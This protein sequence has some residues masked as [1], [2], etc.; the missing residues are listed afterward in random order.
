MNVTDPH[1]L[2]A[3]AHTRYDQLMSWRIRSIL[4]VC[5]SF[6]AF[7]LE[8]DGQLEAQVYREYIELHVS[9]PP[10][11]T[12]VNTTDQARGL[13]RQ[14]KA[15]D[16]IICM[17]NSAD[18]DIFTFSHEIQTAEVHTP[19]VLLSTYSREFHK[20]LEQEDLSCIDYVFTW[21]GNADL[22]L[23]IIKLIEDQKNAERDILELGVQAIL[24]I[25]DSIRYYSTYLPAIYKLVIQQ[26]REFLNDVV[27]EQQKKLRKRARPKILLANN[28][29]DALALYQKYKRSLLGVISDIGFVVHKNDPLSLEKLDAGIDLCKTIQAD[30]PHMPI[31]LQSSQWS[32][33]AF[34]DEL[35]V[36]FLLKYS[37]TL[38][39]ELAQYISDEFVFGDFVVKDPLSGE[40][41]SR[42][43]NLKEMQA[44][45]QEIPEEHL[46]E[47]TSRNRLSKW[48]VSRGLFTLASKLRSVTASD[49]T[50]TEEIRAYIVQVIKDYRILSGQGVIARFDPE[51][52]SRYIWYARSG[53]GP[54]G[55]KARGLAFLNNLLQRYGLANRYPGV[56]ISIPRT[57]VL[58]TDYF[59]HFIVENGLQYVVNAEN[60]TDEDILSEFISSRLPEDLVQQL[61]VF[62]STVSTPLAVRSSSTLEDSNFQPFAGIYSTYMI[63]LTENK[64]QM[65]RLLS[66]A[67]K[68]VYASVYF[69]AARA[70]IQSSGN[71]LSEEKMGIVLQ[72]VCGS[73][74]QGYY[75]PTFS[76]VAKSI[77]YYPIGHE[78][79]EDG[80]VNLAYGLGKL[81]VE[82]G[83]SLRFSPRYPK[84]ILQLSTVGGALRETQQEMYALNLRPE[85]FKTSID[86]GVNIT[87]FTL[88]EADR[89]RN[90]KH[91]ASTWDMQ[92]MRI[93][94]GCFT[95]GRRI[96]TFAHIL[97]YDT[98]PLP[99]ILCDLLDICEKELRCHVEIEF[100]CNMDVPKGQD[101]IFNVLQVRPV[102]DNTRQD[103]PEL[104]PQDKEQALIYSP[105]ALGRRGVE[106]IRD[107]IYVKQ[108]SFDSSRTH[109]IASELNQLNAQL[110][111]QGRNYIL[112]GPGRW[113]SSDPFLGIPV[114]WNH[115][116]EAR[117]M[118]ECALPH[119]QPEPSQGTHFFQNITSLGVGYLTV[120]PARGL[121]FFKQEVVDAL[122]A[123]YDGPFLRAVTVD[124]PFRVAIN[125]KKGEAAVWRE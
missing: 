56:R 11:I 47:H 108:A 117:M 72:S 38:L 121:G 5:S 106:G 122:P 20:R 43:R 86:D 3:L 87:R 28:Y 91:V 9:N 12:W 75:F 29:D 37:K 19:V 1:R 14:G 94:P 83:Q 125:G 22:I 118:V 111:S 112:V 69:A 51:N 7:I 36:G 71:L 84:S 98:L 89:F 95:Q 24:L 63:P 50:S 92:N 62:L 2:T 16:L 55:G 115:I 88:A 13:L 18:S 35:G 39:I 59:D 70:Y 77:N 109:E 44:L 119:F 42:A 31:L 76:G 52:Y 80:V 101:A 41:L 32:R 116:S 105:S 104:T 81:V 103:A 34:A 25:E 124:E 64:D 10:A 33:K 30:D 27:S 110:R 4:M 54:L 26:S 107:L 21:H 45:I 46:L 67:I 102:A 60:I 57:L 90:I 23:A 74:D 40:I 79:I 17:F 58:A 114:A 113:G 99:K 61:K 53:E 49:F 100:A 48:L 78:K 82:G 120:D 65:F 15:F 6:D 93:V 96:V 68:S 66:K 8:E 97:E 123:W 73:Q 85:E